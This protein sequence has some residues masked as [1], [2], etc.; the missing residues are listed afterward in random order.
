MA[1]IKIVTEV[2]IEQHGVYDVKLRR[3]RPDLDDAFFEVSARVV[4]QSVEALNTDYRIY[5][6]IISPQLHVVGRIAFWTSDV[7]EMAFVNR[8]SGAEDWLP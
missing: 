2:E 1:T 3:G 7:V 8:V 5:G 6:V 4:V